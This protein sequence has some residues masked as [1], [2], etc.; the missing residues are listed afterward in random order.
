M[1][2]PKV[3]AIIPARMGSSRFPGKPLYPILNKPMLQWVYERSSSSPLIAQTYIAT[4]DQEIIDFCKSRS[5][6]S[7]LTSHVHLR[8]SD[9]CAEA[10]SSIP[11][12][13]SQDIILMIQ[14]DEPLVNHQMISESLSAFDDPSVNVS[15]LLGRFQ[16]PTDY[17]SP[18]SIKVITDLKF[19]ALTFLRTPPL[20]FSKNLPLTIGKQVCLIPFKVDSLLRFTS[21]EPTPFEEL[22]SIDMMRFVEHS[23]PVRMVCTNSISHPVD[24]PSDVSIVENL[25]SDTL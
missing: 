24:V 16:S 18:N 15:N 10:I 12:L 21:L 1:S 17:I 22:E 5:F 19:N 13:S 20:S 14:G 2:H 3:V 6:D 9:R 11:N 25:L 4:P 8:A 7:I 23:I